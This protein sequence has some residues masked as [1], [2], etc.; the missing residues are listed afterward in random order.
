MERRSAIAIVLVAIITGGLLVLALFQ[1]GGYSS[2]SG[3]IQL[4]G[5]ALSGHL[6]DRESQIVSI[7][8]CGNSTDIVYPELMDAKIVP[9]SSGEWQVT[10]TFVDDSSGYDAIETYEKTFNANLS[11]VLSINTALYDDLSMTFASNDTFHDIRD[12]NMGFGLDIKYKDGSWIYLLT[13]QDAKGHLVL[14]SGTG[15]INR[16]LLDGYILE[17]GNALDGLV[18]AI[19]SVFQYHLE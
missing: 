2:N 3:N 17:P 5:S 6:E 10:A 12:F 8:I 19:H 9:L 14:K 1:N 13:I 4:A 16:N 7:R 11:D 15:L 18:D